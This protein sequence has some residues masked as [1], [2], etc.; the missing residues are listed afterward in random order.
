MM[1][2]KI[3][4]LIADLEIKIHQLQKKL[5]EIEEITTVWEEIFPS[6]DEI[7]KKVKLQRNLTFHYGDATYEYECIRADNNSL[8][9][10]CCKKREVEHT[11]IRCA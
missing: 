5:I 8:K 6:Y 10:E 2:T 4:T 3:D 9:K 7:E 1:R 11:N